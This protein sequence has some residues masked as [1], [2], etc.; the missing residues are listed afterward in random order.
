[1]LLGVGLEREAAFGDRLAQARRGERVLQGL[2]RA[3]VH[4]HVA[5]GDDGQA[6]QLR[7][8]NDGVD[9]VVVAGAMQQLEGDRGAVL[10][11]G[12]QPHRVREHVLEGLRRRGHEQRQALGQAGEHR[13][14]RHLAL[15]VAGCAT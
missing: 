11:P 8:A 9:E 4:Q 2:P 10:E 15:D 1:M 12:L 14:V 3:H 6:G 13:R 7:H 5:G